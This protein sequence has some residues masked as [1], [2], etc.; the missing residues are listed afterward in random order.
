MVT[1]PLPEGAPTPAT[2]TL[3][4]R[5]T[6]AP[7]HQ[8]FLVARLDLDVDGQCNEVVEIDSMAAPLSADNPHGLDL[9][10]TA[11]TIA[12]ESMAGRDYDWATQR[13]WKVQNPGRRNGLG[14]PVAY[15]LV[16]TGCFPSMMDPGTPQYLRAPVI[17]HNLWVTRHHDDE[18]WPAGTYPTQSEDDRGMTRWIADAEDLVGQDVVLWYV[19]GLHHLTRP[20]GLAGDAGG[21][22]VVLAQ[23]VRLLR[24]QPGAGRGPVARPRRERGGHRGRGARPALPLTAAHRGGRLGGRRSATSGSTLRRG[25]PGGRRRR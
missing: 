9:V 7:F 17:G 4:D 22:G 10:T 18:R 23:A 3:V 1:T 24:P 11:T 12:D 2:G 21:H 25:G 6:Y 20:G 5:R 19:F 15:K 14:T 13:S 8:H 16:P